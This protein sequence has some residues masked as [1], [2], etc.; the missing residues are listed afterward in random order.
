MDT[1]ILGFLAAIIIT[2]VISWFERSSN[3]K[4]TKSVSTSARPA[5]HVA[6]RR[7]VQ[8]V[9]PK[10]KAKKTTPFL[11]SSNEGEA[12]TEATATVLQEKPIG[13]IESIAEA[14]QSE[15]HNK[16]TLR[17]AIIWGEVLQRKF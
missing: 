13:T 2:A 15:L 9:R 14:E 16:E 17:K 7:Q 5:Q 1:D 4:K 3:K 6:P 11:D 10:A 12:S 8:N